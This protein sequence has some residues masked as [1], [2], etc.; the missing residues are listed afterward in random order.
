[1]LG[2]AAFLAVDHA[3]DGIDGHAADE[4]GVFVHAAHV[5]W[6]IGNGGGSEAEVFRDLEACFF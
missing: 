5:R 2:D 4:G 3:D 1:M 6:V